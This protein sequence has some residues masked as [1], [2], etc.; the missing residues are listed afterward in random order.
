VRAHPIVVAEAERQLRDA[1]E[2]RGLA[3]DDRAALMRHRERA[4]AEAERL[5][6]ITS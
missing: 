4:V 2:L 3:I 5:F 6:E 1:E